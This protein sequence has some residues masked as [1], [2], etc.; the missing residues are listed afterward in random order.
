LDILKQTHTVE[1]YANKFQSLVA[2]IMTMPPSERDLL[3]K[4]RN[5]LKQMM[6][7]AAGIDPVTGTRWMDLQKFISYACVTD[8]SRIR[9]NRGSK[10]SDKSKQGKF[11]GSRNNYKE[12]LKGKR[13]DESSNG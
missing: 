9:A 6:Q 3:Q 11:S 4:F 5:G 13:P 2:E 10:T 7:I 8:A 12:K 1:N